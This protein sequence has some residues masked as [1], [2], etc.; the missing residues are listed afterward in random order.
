MLEQNE[1]NSLRVI[2][3]R[4]RPDK[5]SGVL[6]TL[7]ESYGTRHTDEYSKQV[8]RILDDALR[9]IQKAEKTTFTNHV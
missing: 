1:R 9:A 3:D 4:V 2:F 8:S 7:L 5:I 6:A